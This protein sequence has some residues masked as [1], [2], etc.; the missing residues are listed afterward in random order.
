MLTS[1]N[2]VGV[3]VKYY[4]VVVVVVV[5]FCSFGVEDV[6]MLLYLCVHFGFLDVDEVLLN[7]VMLYE[8]K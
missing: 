4:Y 8:G 7:G 6:V 3:V 1:T 5:V 2:G